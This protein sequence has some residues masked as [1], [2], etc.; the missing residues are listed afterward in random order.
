AD[1]SEA[2]EIGGDE[3]VAFDLAGEDEFENLARRLLIARFKELAG[4][5]AQD[6]RR[7]RSLRLSAIGGEHRVKR[8]KL[9]GHPQIERDHGGCLRIT[10]LFGERGNGGRGS[11]VLLGA[12]QVANPAHLPGCQILFGIFALAG[13]EPGYP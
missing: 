6:L 2:E 12:Y 10:S 11:L 7:G 5:V 1:F 4:G 13:S 9:R 3:I 8:A